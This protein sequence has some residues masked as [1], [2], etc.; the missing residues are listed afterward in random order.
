MEDQGGTGPAAALDQQADRAGG[1]AGALCFDPRNIGRWC[2][3]VW[4]VRVVVTGRVSAALTVCL[5]QTRH[6]CFFQLAGEMSSSTANTYG[7]CRLRT[8]RSPRR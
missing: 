1:T 5:Q 4:C 2:G 3:V 7:T 6:A 8:T